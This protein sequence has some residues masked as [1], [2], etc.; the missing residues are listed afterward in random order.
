MRRRR[1]QL[2]YNGHVIIATLNVVTGEWLALDEAGLSEAAWRLLSARAGDAV[3]VSH[4]PVLES[5]SLVCAKVYGKRPG[6]AD[7]RDIAA[8]RYAD[9]HLSAFIAACAGDRLDLAETVALTRA[10]ID[11]GEKL[12]WGRA[13]RCAKF[14]M[15]AA[16]GKNSTRFAPRRAVGANC[17]WRCT[18][19]W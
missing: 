9:I 15:T 1:A 3:T 6:D 2:A 5:L 14:W 13:A 18:R 12:V 7:L 10:M 17:R 16:P 11:A 8:G 19:T 4:P